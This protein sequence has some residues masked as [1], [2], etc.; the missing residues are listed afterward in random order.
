MEKAIM[1]FEQK[2]LSDLPMLEQRV[3]DMLKADVSDAGHQKAREF[4]TSY[5]ND[6]A[7]AAMVKWWE[8]G[9]QFWGTFSGGF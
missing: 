4:V 7:R 6:M 9:D 1:E 2:G 8:M 5:T 3:Q